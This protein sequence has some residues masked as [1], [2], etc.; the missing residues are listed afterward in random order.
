MTTV[1]RQKIDTDLTILEAMIGELEDYIVEGD[2]FRTM[3]IDMGRGNQQ[4]QM[5]GGDMLARIYVLQALYANLT[6]AEKDRLNTI[7]T[8][9]EATKHELQTRFHHVLQ[10]EL[11]ARLDMLEWSMDEPQGDGDM[12]SPADRRNLRRVAVIRQELADDM[13]PEIMA[14]LHMLEQHLQAEIDLIHQGAPETSDQ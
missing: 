9:F 7:V 10:R 11:K 3:M 8:E 5:S 4:Y 2:I 13:P 6:G 1:H 12:L 14:A